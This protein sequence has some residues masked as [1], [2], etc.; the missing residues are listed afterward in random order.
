[1]KNFY[2]A[3]LIDLA[4]GRARARDSWRQAVKY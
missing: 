4:A 2:P 3:P 1:M